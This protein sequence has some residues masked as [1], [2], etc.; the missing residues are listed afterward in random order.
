MAYESN[1]PWRLFVKVLLALL[2]L[3]AIIVVWSIMLFVGEKKSY[4]SGI[5]L[6]QDVRIIVIGD[7]H[8]RHSLDP[9]L[10][11]GLANFG[12]VGMTV[13]QSLYKLRDILAAN[14][15]R[16]FTVMLDISPAS[17]KR[18]VLPMPLDAFEG[19]YIFLN[20]LHWRDSERDVTTPFLLFRDRF[21]FARSHAFFRRN[22]KKR[23]GIFRNNCIGEFDAFECKAF[24]DIPKRAA[25]A[26]EQYAADLEGFK[27]D[28]SAEA[29]YA[30]MIKEARAAGKRVVLYVAPWHPMLQRRAS[31]E[32]EA[33]RRRIANMVDAG[34]IL[35]YLEYEFDDPD[36][37]FM[38][39]NHLNKMG[40]EIFS[41]GVCSDIAAKGGSPNE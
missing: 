8:S 19:R 26:C 18:P 37:A 13:E 10:I 17:L 3:A 16:D 30:L 38:D 20:L 33:F 2:P 21:L 1:S 34:D 4:E 11:P 22:T 14:L 35:D 40:A 29:L 28:G 24:V 41:S 6:S 23:K 15:D 5:R 31:D 9:A 25:D 32:M 12:C 27:D 36:V 7:S 39:Q